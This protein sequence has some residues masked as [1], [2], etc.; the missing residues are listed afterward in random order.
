MVNSIKPPHSSLITV[1]RVAVHGETTTQDQ[2][3]YSIPSFFISTANADEFIRNDPDQIIYVA[4]FLSDVI[5]GATGQ[6]YR[7]QSG[8]KDK[9]PSK[10]PEKKEDNNSNS[11]SQVQSPNQSNPPKTRDISSM[12]DFAEAQPAAVMQDKTS[13]T[14][15]RNLGRPKLN[16]SY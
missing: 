5:K 12:V 11:A 2:A 15:E 7:E 3:H 10:E 14:L 1:Q 9:K 16:W 6:V 8:K 4:D 13:Q